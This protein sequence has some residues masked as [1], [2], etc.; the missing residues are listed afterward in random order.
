MQIKNI[1]NSD[2]FTATD[3]CQIT[4]TFGLPT[5]KI[6]EGS[7]AY[8]IMEEG[9]KTDEHKHDFIEWYIIIKG[10]GLMT[11]NDETK[12]V[13]QGDN[14]LIPKDSWHLIKNHKIENLEFYCFCT[15]AFTLE[16]TT[17]KDGAESKES[18]ERQ[19]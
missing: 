10:Q 18:I 1:F 13:K 14:I 19:F 16:G 11:I 17:M 9:L 3:G 6:K 15:P 8:A 4:E 5:A 7:V 2:Y 12:E